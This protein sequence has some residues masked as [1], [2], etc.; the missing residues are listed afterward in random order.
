LLGQERYTDA[1]EP[2]LTAVE[3]EQ[4]KPAIE[5]R[6]NWLSM[7]SSIYFEIERLRGH[8]RRRRS[9]SLNSI[10]ASST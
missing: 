5:P 6:E 9:N 4:A 2:V 8:A 1:L 3:G 10:R 7:L